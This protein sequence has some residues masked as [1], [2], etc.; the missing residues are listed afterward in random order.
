MPECDPRNNFASNAFR[1]SIAS[2]RK[3][4][5]SSSSRS[6]AQST[7]LASAPW[8]RIKS[9]TASPLSS[10][11]IASPSINQ[12]RTRSLPTGA[13][14]NGNRCENSL[15]G[16]L[17]SLTPALSRR[18]RMRKPWCLFRVASHRHA[19]GLI[20]GAPERVE[21]PIRKGRRKGGQRLTVICKISPLCRPSWS[22]LSFQPR[23]A[24][25]T[26]YYR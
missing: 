25:W 12:E 26:Q 4:W 8:R 15:P 14:I 16:R 1:F 13:A 6:N 11:T 18:S 23:C 22:W 20:R 17:I 21:S 9:K 10:Q 2:R 7:A 24:S 3:S 5:P 19:G